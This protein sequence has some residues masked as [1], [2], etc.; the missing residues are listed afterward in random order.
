MK[1]TRRLFLANFGALLLC[2]LLALMGAIPANAA[3]KP[4][5]IQA[6]VYIGDSE[7]ET[8]YKVK[9]RTGETPFQALVKLAAQRQIG[10]IPNLDTLETKHGLQLVNLDGYETNWQDVYLWL[11]LSPDREIYLKK[12]QLKLRPLSR[13]NALR[14]EHFLKLPINVAGLSKLEPFATEEVQKW[15]AKSPN[16]ANKLR[17]FKRSNLVPPAFRVVEDVERVY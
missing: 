14:R 6:S 11:F 3:K 5:Q 1:L 10:F 4:P 8:P 16:N 2:S 15:A 7:G 9:L 13:A 17:K 12:K